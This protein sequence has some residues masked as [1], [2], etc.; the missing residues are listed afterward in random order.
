MVFLFVSQSLVRLI[1]LR[2]FRMTAHNFDIYLFRPDKGRCAT[3]SLCRRIQFCAN[4][5]IWSSL[6]TLLIQFGTIS[7]GL[8]LVSRTQFG[9]SQNVYWAQTHLCHLHNIGA[10]AREPVH[11]NKKN[12]IDI[13]NFPFSFFISFGVNFYLPLSLGNENKKPIITNNTHTPDERCA[14]RTYERMN[15]VLCVPTRD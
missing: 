5:S 3:R 1:N 7:G 6:L 10:R 13:F 4:T 15:R 14:R 12:M 9:W 2:I 8:S 11:E